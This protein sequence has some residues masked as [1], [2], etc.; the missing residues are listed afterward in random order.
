MSDPI[1]TPARIEPA[2]LE[3]PPAAV[4]D[5]VAE[6]AAAS[7]TLGR[8]LHPTTAA[9]LAGVVRIMNTYYSNLIEGHNTRPRDIE[10]ALAGD[11][12]D[13]EERRNLQLEAAAH[14]RLQAEIDRQAAAGILPEPASADFL[15]WLH[16]EFYRDASAAMLEIRGRDHTFSMTPG[17]W[18]S[19]VEHDVAVGRHVPPSSDRVAEFMRYFEH[20]YRLEPLGAAT[21]IVA[22]AA[23]HH[24]FN[25]IHP[26]PD[27]NGRV[28]RLM[29]H[30][31]CLRTAIGAHGL[32]SVSRG[33]A[34]GLAAGPEGRSEYKRMM[35]Y[36]DTPRQGDLDGRGNLSQR[37]LAEFSEWFLRICLD[38]VSFMSDAFDINT[39]AGRLEIYVARSDN[40]KPEVGRLLTEALIRG[41]FERGEAARITALPERSARRVLNDAIAQGLLGSATP[42]G[43]VSLRFP[44]DALEVLF[45]RLF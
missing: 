42:K 19:A 7:A 44:A 15:R 38:Q 35:D 22:I 1:E 4:V 18:R 37:T 31:M 39:L 25:Y 3:E 30:A 40:L 45:P 32:W 24:R 23:A 10:R 28:S 43:P 17:E 12:D 36:A 26:F 21:R 27:G 5:L 34:R 20:R 6:L 2:L 11:L 41:E 8:A 33:L 16:R 29:S 14:V 13:N 9:Q